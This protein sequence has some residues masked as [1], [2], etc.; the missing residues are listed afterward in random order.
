MNCART[1]AKKFRLLRSGL[2]SGLIVRLGRGTSL[3]IAL[4]VPVTFVTLCRSLPGPT[5]RHWV[6]MWFLVL[7]L[8]RALALVTQLFLLPPSG[9][10]TLLLGLQLDA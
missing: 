6:M 3:M 9:T 4:S 7:S 5:L 2:A 10:M 8:L 1:E